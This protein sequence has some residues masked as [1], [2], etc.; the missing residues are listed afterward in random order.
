MSTLGFVARLAWRDAR[1]SWRRLLMLMASVTVGVAA[2][3]AIDSFTD[4]LRASVAEQAHALLGADLALSSRSPLDSAAAGALIDSLATTYGDSLT[5]ARAVSLPAMAYRP[6]RNTARLVQLRTVDPGWPFYGSITTAPGDAWST[7]QEGYVLVDPSLLGALDAAVGDT[8]MIGDAAFPIAGSVVNVPGEVGLQ[9]AFGARVF[10]ASSELERTHL[11]GFGSR[12]EYQVAFR[13][14]ASVDAQAIADS[15]R[16]TLREQRVSIRTV[17]DDSG[18]LTERLSQLGRFLGLVALAALLLGGLGTASAVNVVIRQRLTTIA[19]LRSLGATSTQMMATFLLQATVMGCIGAIVGA[20]LGV[21]VQQ[22]MPL[23][24]RGLVPV[25]V[26]VTVS[27]RAILL[28]VGLGTW[29]ALAFAMLPVLAVRRVPPL[30]ALRSIRIPAA[31]RLDPAQIGVLALLG[32]SVILLAALQIG[33]LLRGVV[34]AA[35]AA[36]VLLALWAT[37]QTVIRVTRRLAPRRG[38]YL[39]RQGVANLHRPANQTTTVVVALGFGAFLLATLFTA[40]ANLL[41]SLRVDSSPD[42]PN[43]VF[44]DIQPD[45]RELVHDVLQRQGVALTSSTPIVAMRIEA[46]DGRP[47]SVAGDNLSADAADSSGPA[48]GGGWARRREYRSTW[49]AQL[50][51]SE[52]VVAGRWFTAGDSGGGTAERPAAISVEQDLAQELGVALGSHIVWNVQGVRIHTVV[53]SLRSVNWARFEPNFF[54]VFAPGVLDDAPQTSVSL[55]RVDDPIRRGQIQRL[56]AER[57]TNITTVDLAL[58][59]QTLEQ[60]VTRIVGAIRFMALFSLLTGAVVL[61][62]AIATSRWQRI[63]ESTLL[64]TLGATRRQVLVVLAVEYAALGIAASLV[65]ALLA[66]VAGWALTRWFF[67]MQFT[68]PVGPLLLLTVALMAL[69]VGV[70]LAGS[71]AALRR[72]PLDVLRGD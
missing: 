39:L 60:I 33:S 22:V 4:N 9:S 19:V 12:A 37:A 63:R 28:G 20:V 56:L 25:D 53:R 14:P 35:A 43:L 68:L 24:F 41:D 18:N 7:L 67:K 21:G 61:I 72:P 65:A 27:L 45:Q 40:Q 15:Y 47:V 42:Q 5:M 69:A 64:R 3:V 62:G 6:A 23:A 50:G 8:L 38:N 13:L 31:R 52:A 11:L 2:L 30:A 55:A 66:G 16:K 58:L 36:A 49:R 10:I 34:F 46:I 1:A 71:L 51:P 57:A 70:G 26:H 44:I 29:T 54:V 32:L 48:S 59:Q 17:A